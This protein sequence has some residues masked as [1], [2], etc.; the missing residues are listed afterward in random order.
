M[1]E[2]FSCHGSKTRD[3]PSCDVD[4]G[5]ADGNRRVVQAWLVLTFLCSWGE[6][7][8]DQDTLDRFF[9][10]ETPTIAREEVDR[11]RKW[12]EPFSIVREGKRGIPSFAWPRRGHEMYRKS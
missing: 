5:A 6:S 7:V 2:I 11:T 10:L 3:C 1:L 9:D 12:H 4:C 8:E